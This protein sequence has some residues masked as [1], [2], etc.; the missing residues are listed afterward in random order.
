MKEDW[1]P[2]QVPDNLEEMFEAMTSCEGEMVGWCLLCNS[3]IHTEANLIPGTN[4]HD[5]EQGRAMDA[6]IR[7]QTLKPRCKPRRHD[8]K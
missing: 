5:C 1:V 8:Q 6:E 7:K 4:S 2:I 3:P